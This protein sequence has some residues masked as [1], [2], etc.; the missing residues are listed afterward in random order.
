MGVLGAFVAEGGGGEDCYRVREAAEGEGC[1]E[2]GGAGA[3]D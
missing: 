2:A 1:A 3:E